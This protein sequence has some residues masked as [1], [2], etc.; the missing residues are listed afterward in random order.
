MF[1]NLINQVDTIGNSATLK[2]NAALAYLMVIL[3]C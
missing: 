3:D 2:H 1:D